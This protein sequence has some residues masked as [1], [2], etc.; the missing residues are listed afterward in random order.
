VRAI[1]QDFLARRSGVTWSRVWM[2]VALNAWLER[3]GIAGEAA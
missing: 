3:H 2:L 1:W